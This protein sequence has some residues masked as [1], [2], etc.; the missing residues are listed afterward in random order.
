MADLQKIHFLSL[1]CYE[2][3]LTAK[4]AREEIAAAGKQLK[5]MIAK[6]GSSVTALTALE[7]EVSG[8]QGVARGRRGGGGG[9]QSA[10]P[11]FGTV[12]TAFAGLFGI[13]HETEMPPTTQTTT[14]VKQTQMQLQ[15]LQTKWDKL[16]KQI[17]E[18][19]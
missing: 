15:E 1:T 18:L 11:S 16:K 13:L 6:G 8:M 3:R 5:D 9:G 4:K 10:S 19:K 14:G 2:G 12:E 17:A 7:Q